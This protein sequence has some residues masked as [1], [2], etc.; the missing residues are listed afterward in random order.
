[1]VSER[2]ESTVMSKSQNLVLNELEIFHA[3]I[4]GVFNGRIM[5]RR[6]GYFWVY[7]KA[8]EMLMRETGVVVITDRNNIAQ[9]INI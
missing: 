7:E 6:K 8:G 4:R 3:L 2:G 9:M 1:M 5:I